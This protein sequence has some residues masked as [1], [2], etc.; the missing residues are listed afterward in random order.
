M[1]IS[2]TKVEQEAPHL[3]SLYKAT[4]INLKK[5]NFDPEANKA[6]VVATI[7]SSGSARHLYDSGEIQRVTDMA[8]AA[9]LVFDD[10]G[11]VPV[12][13]FD[14]D[15]QDLGEIN[16]SNCKDFI[17]RQRRNYGTTDYIAAL[18][19]II[20]QAGYSKVNISSSGGGGGR[21][22]GLFGKKDQAQSEGL[23]VKATATYPTFAIFVT[24]GEPNPGSETAIQQLITEM[25]QL[26]IFVQ[27]VGVGSHSFSFLHSLDD[28]DGRYIDN[29]G[30]FDSKDARTE[31][32]MLAGLLNEFPKYYMEARAK[33]LIA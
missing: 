9:G 11:E 14:S 26:P 6:A 3:V 24:D 29:A 12:S 8:F 30:F 2:L 5:N 18:Q 21:F 32:Q 15:V 33:S 22:G 4:A 13:F 25:S 16:L 31:E 20:K 23:S 1:G 17:T 28:L 7:D 10:D 27:F 19:W